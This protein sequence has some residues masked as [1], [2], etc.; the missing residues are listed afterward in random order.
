MG[1]QSLRGAGGGGAYVSPHG[2]N[3]LNLLGEYEHT[4][5]AQDTLTASERRLERVLAGVAAVVW[6]GIGALAAVWLV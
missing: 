4:P 6:I 5:L 2:S 3:D 1:M